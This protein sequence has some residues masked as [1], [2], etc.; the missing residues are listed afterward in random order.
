[1]SFVITRADSTKTIPNTNI[2]L[3]SLSIV[4]CGSAHD[5]T[6]RVVH[7]I[8]KCLS[9]LDMKT[10]FDGTKEV[11]IY[12]MDTMIMTP[13]TFDLAYHLD[14]MIRDG[15]LTR[16][17]RPESVH[18]YYPPLD[19]LRKTKSLVDVCGVLSLL[20]LHRIILA[21]APTYLVLIRNSSSV[22]A[23]QLARR[24][25]EPTES[26]DS[27]LTSS[28]GRR[29]LEYNLD[30][31]RTNLGLVFRKIA[32]N[33][34]CPV[35]S[36]SR[37]WTVGQTT[38]TLYP[39]LQTSC[40]AYM[41]CAEKCRWQ[42][43]VVWMQIMMDLELHKVQFP[44]LFTASLTDYFKPPHRKDFFI[45]EV[46]LRVPDMWVRAV[47]DAVKARLDEILDTYTPKQKSHGPDKS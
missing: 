27:C 8:S 31:L 25:S 34:I 6:R 10:V 21:C 23:V 42:D 12:F 3:A 36:I 46:L 1:M 19:A 17:I 20:R 15:V 43:I 44:A 11:Q 5:M 47:P 38:L 24:V 13:K 35:K 14:V 29:F 28:R 33:H 16:P 45:N 26:L 22:C 2:R 30:R 37:L 40:Q 32:E 7:T 39:E 9:S 41:F 18:K 4:P